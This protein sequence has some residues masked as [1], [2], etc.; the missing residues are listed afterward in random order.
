MDE[1]RSIK[2]KSKKLVSIPDVDIV[3]NSTNEVSDNDI[4]EC[5]LQYLRDR[6]D[7]SEVPSGKIIRRECAKTLNLHKKYLKE[8]KDLVKTI[9]TEYLDS[10]PNVQTL[11]QNTEVVV[12]RT[13][14]KKRKVAFMGIEVEGDS[15]KESS[16]LKNI[17]KPDIQLKHFTNTENRIITQLINAYAAE[18][19]VEISEINRETATER[20]KASRKNH[21]L[22][23]DRICDALPNKTRVAI[24]FRGTKIMNRMLLLRGCLTPQE[25]DTLRTL[26]N[27]H[28]KKFTQI[29]RMMNRSTADLQNA[30]DM[31]HGRKNKGRFSLEERERLIDVIRKLCK[32]DA[33]VPVAELPDTAPWAQVAADMDYERYPLDYLRYWKR[34]KILLANGSV[35][36][37]GEE[38]EKSD[39]ETSKRQRS[40][41]Q[42]N[43]KSAE[44]NDSTDSTSKR[45]IKKAATEK[46]VDVE[47][48]NLFFLQTL[49][50]LDVE[51]ESEVG[52][53]S[54]ETELKIANASLLWHLLV[55]KECPLD[56]PFICTFREKLDYLLE[57]HCQ[58][59]EFLES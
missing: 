44:E 55:K 21:S 26:V 5:I 49:Q 29:G 50:T 18:F 57:I 12:E 15:P 14:N 52:W 39:K 30:Y 31:I 35:V 7:Q 22:L 53:S 28:G 17:V 10:H 3:E 56:D 23:W 1:S 33:S 46:R 2:K 47:K 54:L 37:D 6:D 20:S 8:R 16:I 42:N 32:V 51:D 4:R 11:E 27:A 34:F 48:R 58:R 43:K 9:L 38:E 59:V 36:V 25:M 40:N 24:M 19:D 45:P 13:E 41:R